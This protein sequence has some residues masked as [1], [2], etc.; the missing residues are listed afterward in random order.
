MILQKATMRNKPTSN[1]IIDAAGGNK[2]IIEEAEK[3]AAKAKR[4]ERKLKI[5]SSQTI[6]YWRKSRVPVE[7]VP[8]VSRLSKVPGYL[9]RPDLPHLFPPPRKATKRKAA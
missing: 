1:E 8:L 4:G 3:Q 6:S 2:A 9:I 7:Y 5:P